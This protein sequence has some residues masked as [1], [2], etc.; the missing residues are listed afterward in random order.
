MPV[1]PAAQPP[2]IDLRQVGLTLD[3]RAGPVEILKAIDLAIEPGQSVAIVGALG[4]G[5]VVRC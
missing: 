1:S 3:S 2:V 5:Q 4:L